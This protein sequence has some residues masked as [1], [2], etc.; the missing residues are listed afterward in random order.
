MS[1]KLNVDN[2]DEY[3][4]KEFDEIDKAEDGYLSKDEVN[5]Y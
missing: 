3:G 2:P 5:E 4:A 1:K